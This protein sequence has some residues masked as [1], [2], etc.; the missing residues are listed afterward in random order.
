MRLLA[1]IAIIVSC[2]TSANQ[3]QIVD[4]NYLRFEGTEYDSMFFP[5]QGTEVWSLNGGEALGNL[6]DYYKNSRTGTSGEIR[7]SLMLIVSPVN[8]TEHPNSNIDAVGKVIAIV[9]ISEDKNEINSCR[10]ESR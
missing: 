9:S 4:G 5:C 10:A 2:A 1:T 7:T 3:T 8:K 6:I